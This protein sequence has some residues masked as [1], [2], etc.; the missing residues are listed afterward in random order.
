MRGGW[1]IL[2]A[3]LLLGAATICLAAKL[4]WPTRTK[5]PVPSHWELDQ[6]RSDFGGGPMLR[7]VIFT[8]SSD[9]PDDLSMQFV[10]VDAAGLTTRSSWSGPQNGKML[11]VQ[12]MP[13]GMFGI[14]RKGQEQLI[15]SD[16]TSVDGVLSVSKD[17]GTLLLRETLTTREGSSYRQVLMF[18][19][20]D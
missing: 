2:A 12:G 18:Y 4:K 15:L 6:L 14:D 11:P 8:V 3:G 10:T 16:G 17:K 7:S 9:K 19:P 13:G 20:E 1:R 5:L